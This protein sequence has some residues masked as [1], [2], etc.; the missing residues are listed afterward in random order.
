MAATAK[1]KESVSWKDKEWEEF[2]G[3]D[4]EIV[5]HRATPFTFAIM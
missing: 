4:Y 2:D 5:Y 1:G 3:F